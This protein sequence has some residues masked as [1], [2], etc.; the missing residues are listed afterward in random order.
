[1]RPLIVLVL[2]LTVPPLQAATG[3]P[4]LPL[5]DYVH[6]VWTQ[7]DGMALGFVLKIFQ[8][9]DGYLWVATRDDLLRFDGMRF[10]RTSTPCTE[11]LANA[12]AA[13]DGG[14]WLI[15]GNRLVR[16]TGRGQFIEVP[17]TFL[18][19]LTG[20]WGV[21][22][23]RIGR[24]WIYGDSIRYLEPDGT[25]GREI[26]GLTASRIRAAVQDSDGTLWVSDGQRVI[27]VDED[28]KE[29]IALQ[30]VLWLTRARDGGVFA[31]TDDRIWHL[32][33]GSAP[34]AIGAAPPG[35]TFSNVIGSMSQAADGGLWS[36]LVGTGLL[37][38]AMAVSR[39]ARHQ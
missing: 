14:F 39:R 32:R 6:T 12:A 34:S 22:V 15:C 20:E 18:Q 36:A 11:R 23:D 28:H 29:D 31:A 21:F 25:G 35:V 33:R 19:R 10:V 13:P 9:T 1:M 38:C 5:R 26:A 2:A 7:H 27:H 37:F 30:G 3:W 4:D 17:Q 8:T 16:R 24:P